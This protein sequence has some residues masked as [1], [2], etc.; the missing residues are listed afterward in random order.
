MKKFSKV[1]IIFM[2]YFLCFNPLLAYSE[3]VILGGKNIGI[4]INSKGLIVVGFYKVGDSYIASNILKV[5]DTILSVGGIEVNSISELSEQIGS[6]IVDNKISIEVNRNNKII[7]V[8]LPLIYED[9]MYK[10]G[11]YIK[12]KVT[13]IG[14]LTYIDPLTNIY[15]ALGHEILLSDTKE[16]VEV[17]TGQIYESYVNNIDRSS[18]GTVGSKNATILYDNE[19]GTVSKN[20]EF[21]IYGKYKGKLLDTSTTSVARFNEITLGEAYIKTIVEGDT[22]KEYKIEIVGIDESKINTTKSITFLIKDSTLI[23][24]TGGIVQGMS[25]SPIIQNNKIIGAVTNVVVDDVEKGYGIFI[26]TMLE[27]G[28]K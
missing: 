21:G 5:G 1:I 28:E 15:G 10:T 6:N 12:D 23:E 20:T 9:N 7:N 2:S 11:L 8:D 18:N 26:R 22:E 25:G 24:T 16:R 14:T 13:G 19:I 27:E 17:K 4:T 3:N